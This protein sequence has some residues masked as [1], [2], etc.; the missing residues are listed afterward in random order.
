M[1]VNYEIINSLT[2]EASNPLL[3]SFLKIAA[4]VVGGYGAKVYWEPAMANDDLLSGISA[5]GINTVVNG[6]YNI[7]S[8]QQYED[9]RYSDTKKLIIPGSHFVILVF[10]SVSSAFCFAALSFKD[11]D[12]NSRL[13]DFI[14]QMFIHTAQLFV[15]MFELYKT[16]P[17]WPSNKESKTLYRQKQTEII[18][19]FDAALTELNQGFADQSLAIENF[20]NQD[21]ID[22]D[23]LNNWIAEQ[24]LEEK[25]NIKSRSYCY[26][27]FY[28]TVQ[29]IGSIATMVG[30]IG[31]HDDTQKSLIK[32]GLNKNFAWVVS[33][34]CMI[35][36][37]FLGLLS[38]YRAI[39]K[40]LNFNIFDIINLIKKTSWI[41]MS[42]QLGLLGLS[43]FSYASALELLREAIYGADPNNPPNFSSWDTSNQALQ[44]YYEWSVRITIDIFNVICAPEI[45]EY[46]EK[47]YRKE[48]AKS[49]DRRRIELIEHVQAKRN[50]A[51]TSSAA[52]FLNPHQPEPEQVVVN[53]QNGDLQGDDRSE[54]LLGHQAR[55]NCC[56]KITDSFCSL[57]SRNKAAPVEPKE[58]Q[59]SLC[60]QLTQRILRCFGY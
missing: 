33:S 39:D 34:S 49:D 48:T 23:Y 4:I 22:E 30:N 50:K 28:L 6:Y 44:P 27:V 58:T 60:S 52:V 56:Q 20:F 9:L 16:I 15:S 24:I 18:C 57:F 51:M 2:V 14:V 46:C 5:V 40:I 45:A 35:P 38:T 21:E 11:A 41:N 7:L 53:I 26:Q 59:P 55:K 25:P 19:K 12:S 43:I 13:P 31:Y 3:K 1:K 29:F 8:I 10:S 17:E 47:K 54:P 42:I 36:V 37:W 32:A